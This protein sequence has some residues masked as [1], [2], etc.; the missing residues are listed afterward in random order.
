MTEIKISDCLVLLCYVLFMLT[1]IFA[2][3][4][5][6]RFKLRKRTIVCVVFLFVSVLG[7]IVYLVYGLVKGGVHFVY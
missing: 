3:V 6:Y 5:T 4:D 1:C 7:S 2:T